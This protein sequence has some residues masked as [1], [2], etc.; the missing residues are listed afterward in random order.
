MDCNRRIARCKLADE[1]SLP[2]MRNAGQQ[3]GGR[4]DLEVLK[5]QKQ[6][7]DFDEN[8]GSAPE[9]EPETNRQRSLNEA[10]FRLNEPDLAAAHSKRSAWMGSS[11]EAL[12]AG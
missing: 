7:P 10:P 11:C 5:M 2:V 9:N 4:A 6:S 8:K 1:A 3:M 12:R